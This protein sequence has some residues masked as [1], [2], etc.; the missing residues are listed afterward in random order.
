MQKVCVYICCEMLANPDPDNLEMRTVPLIMRILR[1]LG[2]RVTTKDAALK[3]NTVAAAAIGESIF[4]SPLR[5]Q[6]GH[7]M[8]R[9][10]W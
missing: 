10:P 1:W 8:C 2:E 9:S 4:N 7:N 3:S 6:R 5:A